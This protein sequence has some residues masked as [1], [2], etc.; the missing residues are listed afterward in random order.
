MTR[1]AL[2]PAKTNPIETYFPKAEALPSTIKT[3]TGIPASIRSKEAPLWEHLNDP[4]D[5]ADL[6]RIYRLDD[7][8]LNTYCPNQFQ[9]KIHLMQQVAAENAQSSGGDIISTLE[10]SSKAKGAANKKGKGPAA[11]AAVG[12][13]CTFHKC[14][15]NPNCCNHLGQDLWL[16]PSAFDKFCE[17]HELMEGTLLNQRRN[18]A[19][20][21]GLT[22]LGA[23]CY[24]NTLLQIWFHNPFFRQGVYMF[25]KGLS[26]SAEKDAICQQLQFAFASMQLGKRK[27]LTPRLFVESMRL[28]RGEQQDA[29]EFSKLLLGSMEESFSSQPE[30]S[31]LI[32]DQFEGTYEYVTKCSS[33]GTSSCV[34]SP[35]HE[36]E[37]PLV[38]NA[39]VTTCLGGLLNGED[40]V[41]NNQ[42]FCKVCNGKRDATRSLVLRKLPKVLNMHLIRFV[43]DVAKGEKLKV[44]TRVEFSD[45]IDLQEFVS[46]PSN[47]IQRDNTVYDLRAILLHRGA[48]ANQGHYTAKIF[49]GERKKWFDFD[50]EVVKAA[51]VTTGSVIELDDTGSKKTK[52]KSTSP[53]GVT[54]KS[55]NVYTLT[56]VRRAGP[57]DVKPEYVNPQPPASILQDLEADEVAFESTMREYEAKKGDLK[58]EFEVKKAM[59]EDVCAT[60]HVQPHMEPTYFVEVEALKEW[61]R[62]D[63]NADD[64]DDSNKDGVGGS[65]S[66]KTPEVITVDDDNTATKENDADAMNVDSELNVMRSSEPT[67]V[68]L[69]RFDNTDVICTHGKLHP[70][71]TSKVK[72]IS[73]EAFRKLSQDYGHQFV[74]ALSSFELCWDCVKD[75]AGSRNGVAKHEDD[76]AYI[77]DVIDA[78]DGDRFWMSKRW[79]FDWK[80]KFPKS[81]PDGTHLAPDAPEYIG[82]FVCKHGGLAVEEKGRRLVSREAINYLQQLFPDFQTKEEADIECEYCMNE[83]HALEVTTRDKRDTAEKQKTQLKKLADPNR[84]A[85]PDLGKDIGVHLVEGDFVKTWRHFVEDPRRISQ[86]GPIVNDSL[87]CRPHGRLMYDVNNAE[88][89]RSEAWVM[90]TPSEW[91]K[92]HAWYGG[93]PDIFLFEQQGQ[94]LSPTLGV[95]EECWNQRRRDFEEAQIYIQKIDD[96]PVRN[97]STD[98]PVIII[99]DDLK[100]DNGGGA[101]A[102]EAASPPRASTRRGGKRD[103]EFVPARGEISYKTSSRTIPGSSSSSNN[104]KRKSPP[105]SASYG[106]CSTR[107][108]KRLTKKNTTA[109][110]IKKSTSVRDLKVMLMREFDIV[111]IYQRLFFNGTELTRNEATMGEL[112]I[113][114]GSTLDLRVFEENGMA[115]ELDT[116][117]SRK[118]E[119]GFE[120]SLLTGGVASTSVNSAGVTNGGGGGSEDVLMGVAS[121]E[122]TAKQL[123][124][125]S[126]E[127]LV[128][129]DGPIVVFKRSTVGN[130]G[131]S[132]SSNNYKSTSRNAG[133]SKPSSG[134]ICKTC[135]FQNHHDLPICEMC[136]NQQQL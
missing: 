40:M 71:C 17:A 61:L 1:S 74:P 105:A 127:I 123:S 88:D 86:P 77:K 76:V 100:D 99:E 107:A 120:G 5:E 111:P 42:Y 19:L 11:G 83:L 46:P 39:N 50:D 13:K 102:D 130:A 125:Q 126:D 92:L 16:Q 101:S 69:R 135:T 8:D 21:V 94:F 6:R 136:E 20:P 55:K 47:S 67:N 14:K 70:L 23:T 87:L 103:E 122:P 10:T 44:K 113:L 80:K 57:R 115:D 32:R 119:R 65:T 95:C 64:D 79:Y 41:G 116:D 72:R 108:S 22:N 35:F 106:N 62:S 104:R 128:G 48:S 3:P 124:G 26:G 89:A 30:I 132:I 51:D 110:R 112:D 73:A 54:F 117:G 84:K 82:A 114:P 43:Y 129:A 29:Q 33:C 27:V 134:W 34:P 49:D 25:K 38:D 45:T 36:L 53:E 118:L 96:K 131:G 60:W 9:E 63:L 24:L 75:I 90:V 12:S 66:E 28:N 4:I 78:R 98:T 31:S 109:V 68:Q 133:N 85:I 59:V 121:P 81:N 37:I 18:P 97:P 56:Y 52:G 7:N 2:P 91:K 93:G 15:D 58:S